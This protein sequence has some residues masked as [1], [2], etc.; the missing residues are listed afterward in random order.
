MKWLAITISALLVLAAALWLP[1]HAERT[2]L[3]N[4]S[5]FDHHIN[6]SGHVADD[7]QDGVLSNGVWQQEYILGMTSAEY[8]R[9]P[10]TGTNYVLSFTVGEHPYCPVHG[11][12]I[13]KYAWRPHHPPLP[14]VVRV[15]LIASALFLVIVLTI[16]TAILA[17][18]RKL[19]RRRKRFDWSTERKE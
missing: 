8:L 14:L 7:T 11:R 5:V 10:T 3:R 1:G 16:S 19:R 6:C 13:E 12:L 4:L 2:C 9:C 15:I 17:M 18:V